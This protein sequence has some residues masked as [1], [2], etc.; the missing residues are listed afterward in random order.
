MNDLIVK[1]IKEARLERGLTQQNLAKHLGR[2]T[3]SISELER[4]KVQ[5]TASDLF[6]IAQ[7]LNKPI[8]YFYGEEFSDKDIQEYKDNG[9]KIISQDLI[10]ASIPI[11]MQKHS[12]YTETKLEIL[13]NKFGKIESVPYGLL[14]KLTYE[15][16]VP[17]TK[18]EYLEKISPIINSYHYDDIITN[19]QLYSE[20]L[21]LS[22]IRRWYAIANLVISSYLKEKYN[23]D[24]DSLFYYQQAHKIDPLLTE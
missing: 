18:E 22:H 16:D 17:K 13:D 21:H 20:H 8:E 3:A 7:L 10:Y 5:V 1:R 9:S 11:L 12:I 15:K 19:S 2:S 14:Y 6:L 23:N 24:K 4:G